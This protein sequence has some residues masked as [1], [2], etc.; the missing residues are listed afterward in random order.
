MK[1][2]ALSRWSF[3]IE[4][5]ELEYELVQDSLQKEL[6]GGCPYAFTRKYIGVLYGKLLL[7]LYKME[8]Y[9]F[10]L[11]KYKDP[12]ITLPGLALSSKS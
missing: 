11:R 1:L 5:I 6:S 3:L 8:K 4:L 12:A 9:N 7:K 2:P 10:S